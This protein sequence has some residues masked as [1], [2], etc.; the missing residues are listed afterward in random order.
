MVDQSG[1]Q[2]NNGEESGIVLRDGTGQSFKLATR[3]ELSEVKVPAI[4]TKGAKFKDW[5]MEVANA[6]K[7]TY[8]KPDQSAYNWITRCAKPGI[9]MA[10]LGKIPLEFAKLEMKLNVALKKVLPASHSVRIEV[11]HLDRQAMKSEGETVKAP[12]IIRLLANSFKFTS[13]LGCYHAISDMSKMYW[14]GDD[15]DS[16]HR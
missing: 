10:D 15:S 14:Y 11:D 3:N 2:P 9:S 1:L 12:Q 8:Q 7:T 16:I 6:V 13:E 5:I 4:P